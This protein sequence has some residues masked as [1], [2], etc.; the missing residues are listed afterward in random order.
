MPSVY[1][2]LDLRWTWNGDYAVGHGGDLMDTSTDA[3]MSLLQDIH[4]V[5]ASALGDWELYPNLG[6]GLDDFIGEPNV[7]SRA[8]LIHDRV[9]LS[10]VDANIV[11][12]SDLKIRVIPV[13]RHRVMILIAVHVV[14][15]S[16]NGLSANNNKLR[17][18][19]VFDFV[20]QGMLFWDKVPQLLAS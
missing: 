14:P 3:L 2:A 9:R 4:N 1:D 16:A 20:E 19:F 18:A 17:T 11:R 6:A 7:R 12:E 15:T 8:N 10:L 13:H 5:C